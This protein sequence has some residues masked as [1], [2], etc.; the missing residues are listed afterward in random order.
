MFMVGFVETLKSAFVKENIGALGLAHV[1]PCGYVDLT[2]DENSVFHIV[3]M[4]RK[5]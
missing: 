2:E 1:D 5:S 3:A 4:S